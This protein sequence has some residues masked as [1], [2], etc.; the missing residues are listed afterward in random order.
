MFRKALE[1]IPADALS[2]TSVYETLVAG[3]DEGS[4]RLPD[5]EEDDAGLLAESKRS[6]DSIPHDPEIYAEVASYWYLK[7]I[8]NSSCGLVWRMVILLH[9]CAIRG[10]AQTRISTMA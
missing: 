7:K 5:F 4:I 10:T 9:W 8:A 3:L 2:L 6:E 1:V